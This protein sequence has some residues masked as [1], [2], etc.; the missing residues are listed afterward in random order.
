MV[1]HNSVKAM[2]SAAFCASLIKKAG[3]NNNPVMC[4]KGRSQAAM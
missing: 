4:I 1:T 3:W 2:Q